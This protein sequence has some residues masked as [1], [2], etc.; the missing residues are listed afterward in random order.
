MK[1]ELNNILQKELYT[2][3]VRFIPR[4]QSGFHEENNPINHIKSLLKQVKA[5]KNLP[6][7]TDSK[8]KKHFTS[9]Q[10]FMIKKIS[11]KQKQSKTFL[12]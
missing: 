7:H 8:Q 10:P 2:D 3:Q 5:T 11:G 1:T 9:Q 12:T 4:V 6:N